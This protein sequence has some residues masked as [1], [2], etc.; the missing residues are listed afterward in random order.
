MPILTEDIIWQELKQVSDPELG[1]N[2]VDLGL[3]YGV[4]VNEAGVVQIKF[5]LTS[6]NCPLAPQ[7]IADIQKT[8][9]GLSG[10][11]QVIS[12]LVWEPAW[13]KSMISAEGKVELGIF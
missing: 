11:A 6:I 2:I 13:N 5:T 9:S 1:I 4:V 12:E 10:C 7:L 3:V 8:I